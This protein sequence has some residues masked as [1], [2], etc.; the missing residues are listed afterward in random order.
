MLCTAIIF[1]T[2]RGAGHAGATPPRTPCLPCNSFIYYA[3]L[4]THIQQII[5]SLEQRLYDYVMVSQIDLALNNNK[6]YLHVEEIQ[7]LNLNLN[8]AWKSE[9]NSSSLATTL[10]IK[11][12]INWNLPG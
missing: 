6:I 3:H 9:L 5:M 11:S 4:F 8:L 2:V 10:L 12:S 1:R 7:N